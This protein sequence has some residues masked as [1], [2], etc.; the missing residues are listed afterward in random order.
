MQGWFF[1]VRVSLR[2][3]ARE[4][5]FALA[6]ALVL[7][8]GI[9]ATTTVFTAFR[10]AVLA[11]SP[12]PAAEQLMI[13]DLTMSPSGGGSER[14]LP[15]SYPRYRI[16]VDSESRPFEALAGYASQSGTLTD[17]VPAEVINLE[18]VTEDYLDLVGRRP[19]LGRGFTTADEVPGSEPVTVISHELWES[20]FGGDV[21]VVGDVVAL[22]S[23]PLR[24]IGV[25]PRGFDGL[26]GG[27]RLWIPMSATRVVY[28]PFLT[29]NPGLHWFQ[30]LG[31]RS[32]A[33]SPEVAV[34]RM[35]AVGADIVAA[36]PPPNT[37]RTYSATARSLES[38]RTNRAAETALIV[39]ISA[40]ALVLL[41]ACA[42]MSGLLLTRGRRRSRS[43]A[44]QAALGAPRARLV[45]ASLVESGVL[46][47]AGGVL[48]LGLSVWGTGLM[49]AAWPARFLRGAD[50]SVRAIHPSTFQVDSG[51]VAFALMVT[52][53][54]A[55]ATGAGPAWLASRS[56]STQGLWGNTKASRREYRWFGLEARSALVG[57]QVAVA[58]SLLVG[59]GLV[60]GS[61]RRLLD[62]DPGFT[63]E[64]VLAFAYNMDSNSAFVDD[65]NAV[66]QLLLDRLRG[67]PGVED[68]SFGCA[69]LRGRCILTR[70][71]RIEG[72]D[73]FV[74]GEGPEIGVR[75]VDEHHFR[76]LRIDRLSG[77]NF[78][79]TD[80]EDDVAQIVLSDFAARTLFGD[81]DAVGQGIQIGFS[82]ANHQEYARV[83]GVVDNVRYGPA[84]SD[85][86]PEAYLYHLD[87]AETNAAISVRVNGD[88]MALV[89]TV[90]E[91]LAEIDPTL[92]VFRVA[93]MSDVLRASTGDRQIVLH[94]LGLFAALAMVLA[95]TGTWAIISLTVAERRHEI[96]LRMALGADGSVVVSQ[97]V[98]EAAGAAALGVALGTLAAATGSRA[99]ESMLWETS[100]LDPVVYLTG[101]VALVTVVILASWLPARRAIAVDPAD[102][103]RAE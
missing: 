93:A 80:A 82:S 60:G 45:R 66:H 70:V 38:V 72:Q 65:P 59:A 4:P 91:T 40:A 49:A 14:V 84:D 92:A 62:V 25:A 99:L 78:Q 2:R 12:Y 42:N 28:G 44:L 69:P 6:A 101:G 13:A 23:I 30:V 90:R 46:A 19:V 103:L 47:I 68:A 71:D 34:E 98:R 83:I 48:G 36:Y 26:T 73:E 17:R 32:R 10:S 96:G 22:N 24:I 86:M 56:P 53:V 52:V 76:T 87:F 97:V 64:G 8:L 77:R 43:L 50:S 94:V 81:A 16:L 85:R 100:R 88:P 3:L 29:E 31:R 102:T 9:G 37:R 21:G 57:V 18:V 20:R 74:G 41:V 75:M 5:R 63:P 11:P 1:D 39:L 7:G 15:W 51:V 27:A 79:P 35:A 33:I 55:V 54:T 95:G 89:P 61:V 58:L 67:L